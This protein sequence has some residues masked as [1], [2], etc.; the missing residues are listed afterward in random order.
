MSE[1]LKLHLFVRIIYI[2]TMYEKTISRYL[3]KY[4][5]TFY[6]ISVHIMS[7]PLISDNPSYINQWDFLNSF[8]SNEY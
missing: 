5:Y 7:L 6:Y 2:N 8:Y 4:K 3:C 1:V